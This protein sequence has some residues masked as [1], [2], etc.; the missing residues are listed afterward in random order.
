[1][2]NDTN[3]VTVGKGKIGGYV[4]RAPVG[5][6]LP[7]DATTALDAAFSCLGYISEDGVVNSNSI[8]S[9]TIKDWNGDTVLLVQ[10]EKTDT[11][12]FTMMEAMNVDVLKVAYG[13][14]NVTGTLETGITV[15]ANAAPQEPATYVFEMIFNGNVLHRVVLPNAYVSEVGEVSYVA[16]EAVGFPTTLTAA[17]DTAG[18]THYEYTKAA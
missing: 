4:F 15:N 14:A 7:T 8:E 18:N 10:T 5:S 3:K 11:W 12:A 17:A 9:E 6:T 1:M 16:G 2:A 13:D